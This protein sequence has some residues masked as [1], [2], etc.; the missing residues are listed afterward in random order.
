[1]KLLEGKKIR[2]EGNDFSIRISVRAM[3]E[4]ENLTGE[5]ISDIKGGQTEKLMKFFYVIAK[6]GARFEKKEFNYSYEEFLDII[7][8][9]YLDFITNLYEAVFSPGDD[10]KKKNPGL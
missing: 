7:D 10:E 1:M 4:Y 8:D 2:I 5:S 3:I 9:H 6:A